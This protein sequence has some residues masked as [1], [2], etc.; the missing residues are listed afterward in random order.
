MTLRDLRKIHTTRSSCRDT[1]IWWLRIL[2]IAA[3]KFGLLAIKPL[4]ATRKHLFLYPQGDRL[5]LRKPQKDK[6]VSL[7]QYQLIQKW[8]RFSFSQ[9]NRKRRGMRLVN[10]IKHLP[11]KI[12]LLGHHWKGGQPRLERQLLPMR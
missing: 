6:P 4:S 2:L 1:F 7:Y 12:V 8:I 3:S 9:P 5:S 11:N 10:V